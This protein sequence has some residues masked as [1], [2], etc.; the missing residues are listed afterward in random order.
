MYVQEPEASTAEVCWARGLL[1][2]PRGAPIGEEKPSLATNMEHLQ[3][4][5]VFPRK[6]QVTTNVALNH[7]LVKPAKRD[8]ECVFIKAA[9]IAMAVE[10]F[11][12]VRASHRLYPVKW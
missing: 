3:K 2:Q 1:S 10:D 6:L 11:R 9:A 5:G 8:S 7:I 12:P 4:V